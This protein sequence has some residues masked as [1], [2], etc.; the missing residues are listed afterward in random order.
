MTTGH[1]LCSHPSRHPELVGRD[2]EGNWRTAKAKVYTLEFS[3]WLAM[4]M[5][6]SIDATLAARGQEWRWLTSGGAADL[7]EL[8][9]FHTTALDESSVVPPDFVQDSELW[10]HDEVC[11]DPFLA[12]EC[13]AAELWGEE[14]AGGC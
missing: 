3:E 6:E 1:G 2:E 9:P 13:A 8:K 5:C 4:S 12:E 11:E 10:S 7:G 14:E